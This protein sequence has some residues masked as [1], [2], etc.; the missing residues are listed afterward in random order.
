[1]LRSS[2]LH[3]SI[4]VLLLLAAGC[5]Q[6][7]MPQPAEV[8]VQAEAAAQTTATA[9][10][11]EVPPDTTMAVAGV[12]PD[13]GFDSKALNGRFS[14][15][16]SCTGCSGLDTTL[17]LNGDGTFALDETRRSSDGDPTHTSGTWAVEPQDVGHRLRLDPDSK[18]IEDR[19][20]AIEASNQLRALTGDG[21]AIAGDDALLSRQ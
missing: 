1:M 10:P 3:A 17:T 12:Q 14:G 11:L 15:T 9:D 21:V 20:F 18:D 6:Q 2:C 4:L 5:Q 8:D 13:A 7:S 19:V 16:L